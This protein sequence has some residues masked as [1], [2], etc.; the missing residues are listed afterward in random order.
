MTV[1]PRPFLSIQAK[2]HNGSIAIAIPRSFRGLLTLRTHNGRVLL[3]SA[4]STCAATLST[5]GGSHSYFVGEQSSSR[6]W[7][8]GN[9]EDGDEVDE[10][11]G[12]SNNGDVRVSYGDEDDD[13]ESSSAKGSGIFSSLFSAMGS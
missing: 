5:S 6:K 10:V 11:I 8:T 1:D 9:S 3:S 13:E 2:A 4:L 7:H 12:S